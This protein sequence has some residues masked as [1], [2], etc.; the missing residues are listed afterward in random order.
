MVQNIK[1]AGT[2]VFPIG[3]GT[4]NI[5][6]STSEEEQEIEALQ[7]GIQAGAQVI[8]TAEMYGSGA[9]EK[10]VGQAIKDYARDSFYLVSK[11]SPGNAS[12]KQLPK[13]LENSLK[14][15][16]VDYLD[17]YLLHWKSPVPLEETVEAM[18]KMKKAGKIKAWG[19]SNFDTPDM[20]DLLSLP[21]GKNCA[22]NQIKYN[23]IDRGSE[24][25]L[26]PYIREHHL[27]LVAYSPII[28]NSLQ[29]FNEHQSQVLAEIA[30]N[31]QASLQQI[32]LAWSIRDENTIAI[33]KSSNVTHMLDNI[34]AAQIQL[35]ASEL[36]QIDD[37]FQ[38]PTEKQPLA[39]W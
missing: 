36:E 26:L 35:T 5:G 11:V 31:H 24:Y 28:K 32:L 34:D 12:K 21:D 19:V 17:L 10:I 33:P 25:D 8:D 30:E 22:T 27:P 15:L 29:Q 9:S 38:K 16:Q 13:S 14:R 7:K 3:L 6:N 23:L 1:I 37:V 18:E 2:S 20:E 39:L 4:W